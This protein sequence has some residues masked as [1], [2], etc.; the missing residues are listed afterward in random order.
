MSYSSLPF[1]SKLFQLTA[2]TLALTLA[3]CGGGD[4]DTVDSIAP[5]PDLGV[6]QP[7]TGGNGEDQTPVES[8]NIA[9]SSLVDTNGAPV[10]SVG[11]DGAY[12][13][14][15]VTDRNSQPVSNAKVSFEIDAD[16][17][18]LSQTTSGSMLTD[19]DGKAR[20]FL[21]PNSP[22]VSGAYT[23]SAIAAVNGN[24]ANN[25]LTF[26]VQ[27]TNVKI[28]QLIIGETS[29]PSGGQTTVSL[30]VTDAAGNGLSGVLVNLNTNCGQL[31]AQ[32]SSDDNG[33]VE[34]VYKA[35]NQNNTLCSGAVRISAS[36][37][38]SP[39][40]TASLMVQAPEANSIVF[41]SEPF[42]LGIKGSGSSATGRVEF[43]VYS[44]NIPLANANVILSLEKSPLGLTFGVLGN[45]GEFP[46]TTDENGKVSVQIYP[47]ETPGPLEIEASLVGNPSIN[48]LS[49]GLYIASSRVTQDGLSMSVG[50]NA[51][52]W[53]IDG[54]NTSIA[55]RL[56]DRNGNKVPDGTVVSFTA[57]G[58]KV[59]PSSCA[60]V[61]GECEV[62]F[63]T[64]NPR[65]GDG[66][67]TV[68]AV[69][70]GE[71]T[72][73]DKNEN[74]AWDEGI[75]TIVH[76]IGDTFRDDNE[77]GTYEIGEFTYPITTKANGMCENNIKEFIQLK[78]PLSSA[79]VKK[80]FE[81][82]FIATFVQ[83]N[84]PNTCNTGLDAVIRHESIQLLTDGRSARFTLVNNLGSPL[85]PQSIRESDSLV[86]IR[87]NSGGFYD[88]NPMP[89]GTTVS[90]VAP[91]KSQPDIK[92][93]DAGTGKYKIKIS[94]LTPDTEFSFKIKDGTYNEKS[95]DKGVV[96]LT[97]ELPEKPE[98]S[99]ISLIEADEKCKATLETSPKVPSIVYT[100]KPGEN[101]GTI[102]TF[103]LENCQKGDK[104]KVSA[105]SPSNSTTTQTYIIQ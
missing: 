92:V 12:Y 98:V 86:R 60:T 101:I 52:D 27:E 31:P 21:K 20:V 97:L 30:K 87:I 54:L 85:I 22:D 15:Q 50:T 14:V 66:R 73:I 41:T 56:V 40:Q 70:E 32:M 1:T 4:G 11:L 100:G 37:G 17:V 35:I 25:Q 69:A 33:M 34:V 10:T 7:G 28:S 48:A 65:P 29:L 81:K 26:S 94:D 62:G 83:P 45:K 36:A 58:G 61:N 72:Y 95:N 105:T 96:E 90:G 51:L 91:T 93:Y 79:E 49:K 43:T 59:F 38:S 42:T 18:T 103:S 67:V 71:K 19:S 64:Q 80:A 68:L 88:L 6:T 57:E 39:A 89:S 76:N 8:L 5:A 44:D 47:G 102:S 63:S 75:D 46:A 84:K 99:D 13:E 3:G 74:N 24:T 16:G 78:F 53:G 2:L 104:F 82:N 55:A 23:I 77:N 9:N